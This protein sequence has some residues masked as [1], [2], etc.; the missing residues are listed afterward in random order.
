MEIDTRLSWLVRR[1]LVLCLKSLC[2]QELTN[3]IQRCL[4][5]FANNAASL[6]YLIRKSYYAYFRTLLDNSNEDQL[7][8]ALYLIHRPFKYL[9]EMDNCYEIVLSEFCT[10][11][12]RPPLTT[13]IKNILIPFLKTK[14]NFPFDQIIRHLNSGYHFDN[15]NSLF[16]C[17]LALEPDDYG[18][19]FILLTKN[20]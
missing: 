4:F 20:D 18:K 10:S 9:H 13:N 8:Q 7:D 12:L 11:F 5:L 14:K 6:E 15:T 2:D 16:Y 19:F 1:F 3:L 17:I